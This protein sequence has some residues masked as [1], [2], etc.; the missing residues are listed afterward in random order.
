MIEIPEWILKRIG[1]AVKGGK[2]V[3]FKINLS[4]PATLIIGDDAYAHNCKVGE[5]RAKK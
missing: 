5:L 3:S 4:E 1:E 2:W